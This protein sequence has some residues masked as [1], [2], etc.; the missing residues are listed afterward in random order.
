MIK[1]SPVLRKAWQQIGNMHF[2]R[3][4]TFLTILE[5]TNNLH[6]TGSR[7]CKCSLK[8]VL[9]LQCLHSTP[10]Q[11]GK[12]FSQL[13]KQ[14]NSVNYK[15]QTG[16]CTKTAGKIW[17]QYGTNNIENHALNH[18]CTQ[19]QKRVWKT[20]VK[21]GSRTSEKQLNYATKSTNLRCILKYFLP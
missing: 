12:Q 14:R 10:S 18:S 17:V 19:I 2:I 16:S 5:G 3:I 15:F 13:R 7:G 8:W 4:N 20:A 9:K 6:V 1:G 11:N 21:E